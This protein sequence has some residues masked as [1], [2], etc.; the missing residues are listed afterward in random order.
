MNVVDVVNNIKNNA[1]L[2]QIIG[3][4]IYVAIF[5][6]ICVKTITGGVNYSSI[7]TKIIYFI[8]LSAPPIAYFIFNPPQVAS[9]SSVFKTI[10]MFCGF[11]GLIY[12]IL[13]I[14]GNFSKIIGYGIVILGILIVVVALALI[15]E[16]INDIKVD[17]NNASA[18]NWGGFLWKFIFY[19]PCLLIDFIVWLNQQINITPGPV[20]TLFVLEVALLLIFYYLPDIILAFSTHDGTRIVTDPLY[21]NDKQNIGSIIG[22]FPKITKPI[23]SIISPYSFKPNP[24]A[25]DPN[26]TIKTGK[27]TNS[28]GTTTDVSCSQVYENGEEN[29][30]LR[31]GYTKISGCDLDTTTTADAPTDLGAESVATTFSISTWVFIN[32]QPTAVNSYSIPTNI[33]RIGKYNVENATERFIGK[34]MLSYFNE[35]NTV[36]GTY[37]GKYRVFLSNND[38]KYYDIIAPEQKWNLFVFN[39]SNKIDVFLNGNLVISAPD[40]TPPTFLNTDCFIVGEDD[41]LDGAISNTIFFPHALTT[42]QQ[43]AQIGRGFKFAPRPL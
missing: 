12:A 35:V 26:F 36:D 17:N 11:I 10:I 19:I 43:N 5:A 41:G 8:L 28:D 7:I 40:I 34:P 6:Y 18:M 29:Y 1:L 16:V 31:N 37:K 14:F 2:L 42:Q 13:Y 22:I 38:T 9:S 3:C 21:L 15:H 4:I 20:W 39:Y 27:G 25:T 24:F 30:K 32:P 23:G 33:L